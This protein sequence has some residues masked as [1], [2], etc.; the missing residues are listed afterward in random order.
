MSPELLLRL[1]MAEQAAERKAEME[2]ADAPVPIE[3]LRGRIYSLIALTAASVI[4]SQAGVEPYRIPQW[5]AE[6]VEGQVARTTQRLEQDLMFHRL[7]QSQAALIIHEV[8]RYNRAVMARAYARGRAD[9]Q[10][11]QRSEENRAGDHEMG[12]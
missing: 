7:V 11:E 3:V 10:D 8:E 6:G 1:Q 12:R 2:Y 9:G 5:P 4:D